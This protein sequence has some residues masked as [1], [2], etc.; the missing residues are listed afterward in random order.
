MRSGGRLLFNR[1]QPD[2]I[3]RSLLVSLVIVAGSL[4]VMA[5]ASAERLSIDVDPITP[6]F[7]DSFSGPPLTQ[8]VAEG[9]LQPASKVLGSNP[10]AL[11]SLRRYPQSLSWRFN[12]LLAGSG[13]Q[14]DDVDDTE[15]SEATIREMD[16]TLPIVRD[17]HVERHIDYFHTTIHDRF[18]KWLIRLGRYQP[19]VEQVLA[20]FDLPSDLLYLA[21]IESG[22]NPSAYSRAR[23]TGPWQFMKGTAKRYGLRINYY[24]DERRDPIKSTVAAARHL[25]DLY[26]TFGSWPLAMA[27]YN[28]GEGRVKRALRKTG[29]ESFQEIARTRYLRRETREYVPRFMA[30]TI[31]AKNPEQYGF[32]LA[33]AIPHE[34][35]EVL[36]RRPLHLRAVAKAAGISYSELRSLNPELR[37]YVT[38][39]RDKVYLLKVPVST[40]TKVEAVL[41]KISSWKRSRPPRMKGSKVPKGWYRVRFGD[42]LWKIAKRFRMSVKTLKARNNLRGWLI[43]PGDLLAIR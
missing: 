15:G 6:R 16:S 19:M 37:R 31:I 38:P 12:D 28:A 30:A 32:S 40:G 26:D 14:S 41:D 29:G 9:W 20:E 18:E 21:L 7:T 1:Q 11:L 5:P 17:H 10:T 34:F 24:V 13:H 43:R 27:A 2:G 42:S 36:V 33:P 22:F 3:W 39:P 23:A 35:E 4:L 8:A 25:R